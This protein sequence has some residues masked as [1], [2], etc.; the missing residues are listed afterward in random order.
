MRTDF[1]IK[2][3]YKNEQIVLLF[4]TENGL[5]LHLDC[6]LFKKYNSPLLFFFLNNEN[7]ILNILCLY[8]VL[9]FSTDCPL[10]INILK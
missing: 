9:A 3:C 8:P 7:N 6:F 2:T 5:S 1:I 10:T 4:R